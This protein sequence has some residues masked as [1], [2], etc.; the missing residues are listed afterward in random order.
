MKLHEHDDFAA[1]VTAAAAENDLAEAFIEKDYWITEILRVVADTLGERAIFKGGTSR[2]VR[3]ATAARNAP[4]SLKFHRSDRNT[5]RIPSRSASTPSSTPCAGVRYADSHSDSRGCDVTCP[6][7]IQALMSST[8]GASS[9]FGVA[10]AVAVVRS[11]STIAIS[12]MLP[13]VVQ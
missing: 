13:P 4:A 10:A 3:A 5:R 7:M 1:F 2:V 9:A 8:T 11:G 12:R 6:A